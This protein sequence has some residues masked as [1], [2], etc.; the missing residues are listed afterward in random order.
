MAAS[1]AFII[2][3]IFQR[4]DHCLGRETVADGIA[5]GTL[6]AFLRG[7]TGALT[8]IAAVGLDLS[9]GSHWGPHAMIGFVLSL[10]PRSLIG[11]PRL[12]FLWT[13]PT[14][15][16][17]VALSLLIVVGNGC[18]SSHSVRAVTVGSTPAFF[19]H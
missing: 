11:R 12:A 18:V 3:R 16:R 4:A 1:K 19:H 6:F 15:A 9:E 8:S 14:A 7:R 17:E 13:M 5:A 2:F 10:G